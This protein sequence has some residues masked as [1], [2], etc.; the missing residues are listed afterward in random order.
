LRAALLCLL[1]VSAVAC[2][3]QAATTVK[4][5]STLPVYLPPAAFTEANQPG[6]EIAVFGASYF[7]PGP[8]RLYG[9]ALRDLRDYLQKMTG[10]Q[11]PLTA[12]DANAKSGVFAGTFAQFPNFK[13]QQANSQKRWPRPTPKPLPSKRKATSFS[14][15]ASPIWA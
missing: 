14:F 12:L 4:Q 13:P 6:V 7:K 9:Y 10:A 15:W 3:A 8:E 2:P 5:G 11:F 1:L